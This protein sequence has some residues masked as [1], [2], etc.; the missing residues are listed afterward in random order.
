[1]AKPAKKKSSRAKRTT[2][3]L[4]V[5]AAVLTEAGY[6]C[7]VPTCRGILALDIHHMVQVSEGGGNVVGNLL[8]LCLN[9]H[10]LYHRGTISKESIYVWKS[11]LVSLTRAFDVIALD[12]LVFLGKPETNDLR[13]SGDGILGFARL[14]S[15]GLTTFELYRENGPLFVYTVSLTPSGKQ[16]VS[17]WL[18]GNRAAVE[19]AITTLPTK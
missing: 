16:L 19:K 4:D 6:R 13:V 10:G 8:A 14:I 12:Q 5:R 2:I 3:P 18:S 1:L 9:C 15:A 17:A 7:A 11:V